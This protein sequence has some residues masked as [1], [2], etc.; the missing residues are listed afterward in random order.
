[1]RK[2]SD[3]GTVVLPVSGSVSDTRRTEVIVPAPGMHRHS[4]LDRKQLAESREA[5]VAV[6]MSVGCREAKLLY[7]V[8]CSS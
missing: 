4:E 6:L 7:R 1:M 3:G 2:G 8:L 5:Q